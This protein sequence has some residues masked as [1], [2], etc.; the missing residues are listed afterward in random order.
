MKKTDWV[1]HKAKKKPIELK[2]LE[3]LKKKF[4]GFDFNIRAEITD[5][6]IKKYP[7]LKIPSKDQFGG[8]FDHSGHGFFIKDQGFVVTQKG[9]QGD[10]AKAR[11]DVLDY[12]DRL[13][14]IVKQSKP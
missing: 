12:L 10:A 4:K 14:S 5:W 1:R 7:D 13:I 11:I 2:Y 6:A 9:I 8:T 3:L